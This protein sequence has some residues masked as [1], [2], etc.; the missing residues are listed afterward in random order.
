MV[1]GMAARFFDGHT[2]QGDPAADAAGCSHS[3]YPAFLVRSGSGIGDHQL[4]PLDAQAVP[5]LDPVE[6]HADAVF[7]LDDR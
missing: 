4:D 1:Q 2:P 7:S 6:R 3:C 5:T